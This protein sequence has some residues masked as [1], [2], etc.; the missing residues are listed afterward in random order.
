MITHVED[1]G[2]VVTHVRRRSDLIGKPYQVQS[3]SKIGGHNF[4][5]SDIY[6]E[7]PDTKEVKQHVEIASQVWLR[8]LISFRAWRDLWDSF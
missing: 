5:F 3:M 2:R 6:D 8:P 7:K 4:S 1:I